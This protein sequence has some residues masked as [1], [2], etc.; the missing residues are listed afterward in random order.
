[1]GVS[2]GSGRLRISTS[3]AACSTAPAATSWLTVR[4]RAAWPPARG[5]EHAVAGPGPMG[6][7]P[8]RLGGPPAVRAIGA[9]TRVAEVRDQPVGSGI[10]H[11]VDHE[12]VESLVGHGDRA[13]SVAGDQDPLDADAEAD[14]GCRGAAHLLGGLVLPAT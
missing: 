10:A 2:T 5:D 9:Q 4:G 6:A 3:R 12:R 8:R 13:F 14:A 1:M 7:L 11:E